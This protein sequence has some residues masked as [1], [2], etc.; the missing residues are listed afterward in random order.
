MHLASMLALYLLISPAMAQAPLAP[1][2]FIRQAAADTIADVEAARLMQANAETPASVRELGRQISAEA[3]QAN[4]RLVHLAGPRNV[5]LAN[6]IPP[7]DSRALQRLGGLHGGEF[8]RAYLG[9]V[10][11]DLQRDQVLYQT[12]AR[13]ADEPVAQ[14]AREMLPQLNNRLMVARAVYDA[15]LAEGQ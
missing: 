1:D 6:Q 15:Q 11:A 10:M 14:F 13:L 3:K 12:A 2:D 4:D 8:T 7:E 5:P 9:Y